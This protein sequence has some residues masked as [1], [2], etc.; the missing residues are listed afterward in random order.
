MTFLYMPRLSKTETWV[1][2]FRKLLYGEFHKGHQ[3]SV[4]EHRGY[5]RLQVK[6]NGGKQTRLLPYEWSRNGAS[7]AISEIKQIYKRFY[8]GK[9]QILAEACERVKVSSSKTKLDIDQLI[10][11][12]RKFVPNASDKTWQKS[13][14]PVLYKTKELLE[15]SKGKP[16]NGEDLMFASL[17]QWKQGSRQRQIQRRSLNKFLNW[18]VLRAKLPASYAPP[19]SIPEVRQPKKIGFAFSEQQILALIN[20]ET[21]EK[22]KFAFQLLSVFGLRPEELRHLKIIEGT[23]GKELWSTYR[24]SMG[25]LKG[26][27]TKPR[28]LQ[29][30]FVKDADGNLL[31]WKL[32]QRLEIG[33]ELPPLGQEGKGSE[34]I[35]THLRRKNIYNQIKEEAKKI[36]Q[37][38]VPYSFRHRYAK[39]SHA[40]NI[41]IGNICEAMGHTPEVHW[42]NYARFKPDATTD[43][44]SKANKVVA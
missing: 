1:I 20:D 31:D 14:L 32:Q 15:R 36:D 13:Y 22:W 34:A 16:I 39:E 18:A 8:E 19:A 24:K 33:E 44:Y 43:L 28:K 41:P 5:M 21:D 25:G 9:N 30:L 7:Q 42:Q 10:E 38:C 6:H 4:G 12:F 40:N 11:E 27:K 17:E 23:E 37:E 2:E 35:R 26:H 3:W 29:P